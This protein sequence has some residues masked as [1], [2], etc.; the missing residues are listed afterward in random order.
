MKAICSYA[1]ML[2][3]IGLVSC[4]RGSGQENKSE[5]SRSKAKNMLDSSEHFTHIQVPGF[6]VSQEIVDCGMQAGLWESPASTFRK[7]R[8]TPKAAGEY[9]ISGPMSNAPGNITLTK[10]VKIYVVAV[11]GIRDKPNTEGK[12]KIVEFTWSFVFDDW[13]ASLKPCML[14]EAK[15]KRQH[16]ADGKDQAEFTLYDD[17]WRLTFIGGRLP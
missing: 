3:L 7:L 14:D 2:C 4:S 12:Q 1:G 6:D 13:P 17:G 16:E 8:V 10:A 11:E 9:R 15:R 5:L